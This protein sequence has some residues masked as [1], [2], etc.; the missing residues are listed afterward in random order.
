VDVKGNQ[1]DGHC[2]QP[3]GHWKVERSVE[4][5]GKNLGPRKECEH[6]S[7]LGDGVEREPST[8]CSE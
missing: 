2:L 3:S 6:I 8:L 4:K 7:H 1:S 5:R